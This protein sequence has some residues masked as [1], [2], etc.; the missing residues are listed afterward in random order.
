MK[1]ASIR[2]LRHDS[3]RVLGWVEAGEEVRILRRG[4]AIA[5]LTPLPPDVPARRPDFLARLKSIYGNAE[6]PIT[7]T[8]LIS[9]SRGAR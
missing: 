4:K 2:E 3:S 5:L 7:G 9:E 1:E 8:R 6:L